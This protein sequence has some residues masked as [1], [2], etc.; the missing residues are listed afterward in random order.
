METRV[1]ILT[2]QD[3]YPARIPRSFTYKQ[4]GSPLAFPKTAVAWSTMGFLEKKDRFL[5]LT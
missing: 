1:Q 4:R 3:R 2:K 5:V